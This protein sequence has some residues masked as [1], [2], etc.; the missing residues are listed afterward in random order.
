MKSRSQTGETQRHLDL[1]RR[2]LL[3]AQARGY[4]FCASEVRVPGSAFRADVVAC[5]PGRAEDGL[6]D[7]IVFECKQSRAD[8]LRD[9]AGERETADR[10]REVAAR[11]AELER[12]LGLHLPGLRRGESLF[13][14]C[15]AYDLDEIRH[16]GLRSVRREE[17]ILLGRLYGRMKFDRMRRYRKADAHYLAVSPGILEAHEAPAGWGVLV[18]E[19]ERDLA[20]IRRAERVEC[21]P[22]ARLA[23]VRAIAQAATRQ[24]NAAAGITWD[25]VEECRRRTAP[26]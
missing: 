22:A 11:R 9:N 10:L 15:D 14:E 26:G 20:L 24:T 3:W 16:E 4:T 7:A 13:A 1:K 23:L 2:A 21:G 6:L 8:L 19:G 17:A 25:E 5:R 18:A 12:M